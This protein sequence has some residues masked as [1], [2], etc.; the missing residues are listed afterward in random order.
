MICK[1]TVCTLLVL[2]L[3]LG[4][5]ACGGQTSKTRPIKTQNTVEDVLQA[6]M[7]ASDG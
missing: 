2:A 7:Q 5:T 3:V 6:G 4:L 1:K